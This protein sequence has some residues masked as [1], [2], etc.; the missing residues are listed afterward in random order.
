MA[1]QLFQLHTPSWIIS[2]DLNQC[3]C[4]CGGG[5]GAD[6]NMPI[7]PHTTKPVFFIWKKKCKIHLVFADIPGKALVF[8]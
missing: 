6:L 7:D 3:A 4:V 2:T 5:E 8:S 1:K